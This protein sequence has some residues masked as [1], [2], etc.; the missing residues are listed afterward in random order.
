[1]PISLTVVRS[2]CPFKKTMTK[3]DI[4]ANSNRVSIGFSFLTGVHD[5]KHIAIEI[6]KLYIRA[7]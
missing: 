7:R 5:K 2:V 6:S 3:K 4:P 1:M